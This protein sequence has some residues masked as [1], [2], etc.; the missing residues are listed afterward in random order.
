MQEK[1]EQEKQEKSKIEII[2]ENLEKQ[3]RDVFESEK[4][5][6]YINTMNKFHNYS[7]NNILLINSQRPNATFVKGYKS[8]QN[9]M[10]HQVQ[11]GEKGI[12]ILAP[13]VY[14]LSGESAMRDIENR[15]KK[16]GEAWLGK[17][18]ITK[19]KNGNF[20]VAIDVGGARQ[21]LSTLNR[22]ELK[23]FVDTNISKKIIMGFRVE[24]VFDISQTKPIMIKDKDGNEVLHPK[25]QNLRFTLVDK[26]KEGDL[27]Q[28]KR[29][30]EAVARTSK[31]NISI[32]NAEGANGFFRTATN[33]IVVDEKLNPTHG[34]KT[35]VH[36]NAHSRLHGLDDGKTRNT[37]EV[38][39]EAVA[40]AVCKNYGIDTSDY[41]FGY[42]AGW[43]S[44]KEVEELK[45][46]LDVIKKESEKMIEEID[47]QLEAMKDKSI[48]EIEKDSKF[49]NHEMFHRDNKEIE[50]NK[51]NVNV[52]VQKEENKE[53]IEKEE[54]NN[55]YF[56]ECVEFPSL[57]EYHNNLSLKEAI[58]IYNSIPDERLNGIKGIG[59]TTNIRGIENNIDLLVA[60]K[61]DEEF[62]NSFDDY[63][64]NKEIQNSI[65]KLKKEFNI[66]EIE[67]EKATNVNVK[68]YQVKDEL[69]RDFGYM[70]YDTLT[71]S[72]K[73]EVSISN[74]NKVAEFVLP[75]VDDMNKLPD[76]IY[77]AGNTNQLNKFVLS[78]EKMRS[79]SVS[80]IIVINDKALYVD[81]IGFKA[82]D[83]FE[84]TKIN[85]EIKTVDESKIF[86]KNF[87]E[88][89]VETIMSAANERGIELSK[90]QAKIIAG[91]DK[92]V[93]ILPNLIRPV[94][95]YIKQGK[96]LAEQVEKSSKYVSAIVVYSEN[97]VLSD[98]A[99]KPI[100]F[101]ELNKAMELESKAINKA[102][103]EEKYSGAYDKTKVQLFIKDGDTLSVY[104]EKVYVGEEKNLK[105]SIMK[106]VE[107][108]KKVCEMQ[109]ETKQSIYDGGELSKKDLE[110]LKKK[111]DFYPTLEKKIDSASRERIDLLKNKNK[112]K[113]R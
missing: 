32:G 64:N 35:L 83:N 77:T 46:S 98:M 84:E 61:I 52:Q 23:K 105:E 8:W 75:K 54:K 93:L 103:K 104:N 97:K 13:N 50:E 12:Q 15:I 29:L 24:N 106:S 102:K 4:F 38:E 81:D 58:D 80:D 113:E 5:K 47:K 56:A 6:Q 49:L 110:I 68:I 43:S 70:S 19:N 44:D 71:N 79:L 48:E 7:I 28:V 20:D 34:L 72:R 62:I 31:S 109:Y 69:T 9:D 53:N 78:G 96:E 55:Y 65:Q 91:L 100:S 60:G 101:K 39:A 27:E 74:Y 112:E 10:G 76:N 59:I 89:P 36:E 95:K 17:Y 18:F 92:E 45:N 14:S 26:I 87:N 66:E 63:K 1:Q 107:A 11:R 30:F 86:L 99:S 85:K 37:E 108:S 90:N 51:E 40:Y 73:N 42:L 88:N 94:E 33:E 57:G 16:K 67:K 111:L 21:I 41:S 3:V 82:I 25:A 22:D 2:T